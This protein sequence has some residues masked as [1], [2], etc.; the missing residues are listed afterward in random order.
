MAED[1]R[2][3]IGWEAFEKFPP[4]PVMVPGG[5]VPSGAVPVKVE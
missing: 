2:T 4:A 3:G 5:V 1:G